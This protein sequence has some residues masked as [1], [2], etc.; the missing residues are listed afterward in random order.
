MTNVDQ[1]SVNKIF[2]CDHPSGTYSETWGLYRL[3]V[4]GDDRENGRATSGIGMTEV[5]DLNRGVNF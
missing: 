3:A 5:I 4:S 1:T 2:M